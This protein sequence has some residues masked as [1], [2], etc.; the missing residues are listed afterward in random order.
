MGIIKLIDT[1]LWKA[2]HTLAVILRLSSSRR[3]RRFALPARASSLRTSQPGRSARDSTVSA[4]RTTTPT[5]RHT[6]SCSSPLQ[7]SMSTLAVLSCSTRL[8]VT[9][10]LM[11][12]RSSSRSSEEEVFIA[13]LRSTPVS[14]QSAE[15]TQRRPLRDL[16]DL[17]RDALNTTPWDADSLNGELF[18]RLEMAAQLRPLSERMHTASPDTDPSASRTVLCQSLSQRSFR[19]A[20]TTLMSVLPFR[21]EFS[22]QSCRSFSISIF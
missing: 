11:A 12:P 6:E 16:T 5:D 17:V 10:L 4:S 18:L 19:M 1:A 14:C 7:E 13:V 21:R 22:Q 8:S 9:P 2:K 20:S 3:L 15:L